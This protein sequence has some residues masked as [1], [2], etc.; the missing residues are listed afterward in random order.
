MQA[1]EVEIDG[2]VHRATWQAGA[3]DRLTVDSAFGSTYAYRD[4]R[5]PQALAE[6]LLR[7]LVRRAER[8]VG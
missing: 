6:S 2:Q 8:M 1:F 3:Y 4:G 7:Q 5:P